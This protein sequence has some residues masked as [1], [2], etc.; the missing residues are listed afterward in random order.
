MF[1]WFLSITNSDNI[2]FCCNMYKYIYFFHTGRNKYDNEETLNKQYFF[3]VRDIN[4]DH[5]IRYGPEVVTSFSLIIDSFIHK[6]V[7]Y[8]ENA[9]AGT[10]K[11][12]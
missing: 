4:I 10:A 9:S 8:L 7:Y 6:N 5:C 11:D 12:L 1:L 3:F 2:F